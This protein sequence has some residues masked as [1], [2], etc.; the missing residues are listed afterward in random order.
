MILP[1]IDGSESFLSESP[2]SPVSVDMQALQLSSQDLF[3]HAKT[4]S[5][6]HNGEYYWL[7][8][9]RGNKLILTK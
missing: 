2:A 7:R 6:E 3:R 5:I 8:L 4:V 1:V 9:T